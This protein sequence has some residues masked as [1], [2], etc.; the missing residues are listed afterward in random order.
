[1][2]YG[3]LD[4]QVDCVSLHVPALVL[5]YGPDKE[6]IKIWQHITILLNTINAASDVNM[7]ARQPDAWSL[8]TN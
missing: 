4:V 6:V 5:C 8:I 2:A 7:N 3:F 1:M